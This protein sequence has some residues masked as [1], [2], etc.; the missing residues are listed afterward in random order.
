MRPSRQGTARRAT[1]RMDRR[2]AFSCRRK[3][4]ARARRVTKTSRRRLPRIT[5]MHPRL[6]RARSATTRTARAVRRNSARQG[7]RSVWRVTST[8]RS[9]RRSSRADSCSA[10]GRSRG[11]SGSSR[12]ARASFSTGRSCRDIRPSRIQS[13]RVRIRVRGDARSGVRAVT[14]RT[15]RPEP[16]CSASVRRG[17]ARYVSNATA[18]DADADESRLDI[19]R[20][21]ARR[22]T[23]SESERK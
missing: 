15:D 5:C 2:F 14:T 22:R 17:S 12:R 19:Q 6:R 8:C 10:G 13:M 23:T 20:R 9:T 11:S 4:T 7:M 21:R 18:S 16:S 1:T 3:A